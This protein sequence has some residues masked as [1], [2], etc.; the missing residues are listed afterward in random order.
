MVAPVVAGAMIGAGAS[1]LGGVISD[2]SARKQ[3]RASLDAQREFAQHGIRWRVEDAKAAGLHPLYALGASTTGPSIPVMESGLG[4][5]LSEA[6]QHV[7]RAVA[8]QESPDQ[9][10]A[11]RWSLELLK[12]QVAE[13][14]AR[15][16]AIYSQIMRDS[17]QAQASS[18]GVGSGAQLNPDFLT[19]P[20]NPDVRK[21]GVNVVQVKPSEVTSTAAGDRS[22]EAATG[23]MWKRYTYQDKR[24]ER[25]F[26][27]LFGG[28]SL[29]EALEP[30]SE[31]WLLQ[32]IVLKENLRR[33]PNFLREAED[34]L[35]FGGA[36]ASVL[37]FVRPD[38]RRR[39]QG[40]I[41]P[42]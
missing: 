18:G 4:R 32:A 3:Q 26:V 42:Q 23:P 12:S 10:A 41:F 34:V 5:G 33:N 16:M 37:D 7:G 13:S 39:E 38:S 6:G 25:R 2:K 28:N 19:S 36:A 30:I 24:G 15:Q 20:Q 21:H 31:S 14:D 1:L 29:T 35:P 11:R 22:A 27:W 8:A 40:R 9:A 17:Q